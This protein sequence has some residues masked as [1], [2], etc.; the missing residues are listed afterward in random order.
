MRLCKPDIATTCNICALLNRILPQNLE[1]RLL[2]ELL[3][4]IR[5]RLLLGDDA[6]ALAAVE[7]LVGDLHLE[8]QRL[9]LCEIEV[10]HL[11][12]LGYLL[13]RVLEGDLGISG[14]VTDLAN[15]HA[16]VI[17]DF[18]GVLVPESQTFVQFD[19]GDDV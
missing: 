12:Q 16:T 8:R 9:N 1:V 13:H 11:H 2:L 4:V 15:Q 14:H 10:V 17:R 6:D 18:V 19:F 3:P 7:G 5:D